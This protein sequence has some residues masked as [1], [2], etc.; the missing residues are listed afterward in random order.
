MT[1]PKT[2]DW[3]G[4]IG[5]ISGNLVR[6][7]VTFANSTVSVALFTVSGD[8]VFKLIAVCETDLTS[9]GACN[10]SVGVVGDTAG[11]IALT[12]VTTIDAGEVW[13]AAAPA[14]KD[15]AVMSERA[16]GQ[17]I[18]ATLSAQVDAGK[19]NFYCIWAPLA[20]GATVIAA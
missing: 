4:N 15:A 16:T 3:Y 9:A 6:K 1:N 5:G 8:V 17:S 10:M 7:S 11:I 19:I 18:L 14:T 13:T 12:D 20:S 2:G